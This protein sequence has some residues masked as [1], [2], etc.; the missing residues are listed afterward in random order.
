[1][2]LLRLRPQRLRLIGRG[3]DATETGDRIDSLLGAVARAATDRQAADDRGR[4]GAGP[5]AD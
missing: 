1:M 3:D 4:G 2:R 5:D